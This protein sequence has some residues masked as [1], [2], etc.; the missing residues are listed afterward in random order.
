[1]GELC[2]PF[3][4]QTAAH[5]S[6]SLSLSLSLTLSLLLTH[7]FSLW[8][9]AHVRKTSWSSVLKQFVAKKWHYGV[10]WLTWT[11]LMI[12]SSTNSMNLARVIF[13]I[14]TVNMMI[15][16]FL[17]F[18][19]TS[20]RAHILF[21]HISIL[22]CMVVHLISNYICSFFSKKD[23]F[24]KFFIQVFKSL[25]SLEACANQLWQICK[26]SVAQPFVKS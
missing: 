12:L 19:S 7:S 13:T 16:F 3:P 6:I 15:L 25:K 5:V 22:Y 14:L 4:K 17:T 1:M 21:V 24:V 20:D 8:D 11:Q 26:S 9:K 2:H 18:L 23:N 10:R